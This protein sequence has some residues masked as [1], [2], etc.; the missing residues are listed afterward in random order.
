LRRRGDP[1]FNQRMRN[2]RPVIAFL[3]A[4]FL[5]R[6]SC[7][8]PE[9]PPLRGVDVGTI[10]GEAF[11]DIGNGRESVSGA[12]VRVA[13]LGVEEVTVAGAKFVLESIP[14]G[15]HDVI[16][17][18]REL[19]RAVRFKV[20]IKTA[21][22]TL[23]LDDA[24][25][26]LARAATVR[27]SVVVENPVDVD[28]FLVGGN[29]NDVTRPGDDGSYTLDSVPPGPAQIAFSKPGFDVAVV[30]INLA[31]GDNDLD[32][33]ALLRSTATNL[34]L[35]GSAQ[36]VGAFDHRGI[37][38]RLNDGEAVVTTEQTGAFTFEALPPGRY[39]LTASKPGFRTA[40]LPTVALNSS[41]AVFGLVPIFLQPGEDPPPPVAGEV[42]PPVVD[43]RAPVSGAV[44]LAGA[45]TAF[46]AAVQNADRATLA[47]TMS[48]D[49]GA[50]TAIGAG[51]PLVVTLPT[52]QARA[53]VDVFARLPDGTSDSATIF[54]DPIVPIVT[55]AAPR[56]GD[57]LVGGTAAVLDAD[58]R[59]G[60]AANLSWSLRIFGETTEVPLG[61]G[62]PVVVQLP[63][64]VTRESYE[65][66]ARLP[67]GTEDTVVVLVDPSVITGI[68]PFVPGAEALVAGVAAE[69]LFDQSGVLIGSRYTIQEG[70]PLTI[71]PAAGLT[72]TFSDGTQAFVGSL[73]LRNLSIGTHTFTATFTTDTGQQGTTIIEIVVLPLTFAIAITDPAIDDTSFDDTPIA[74]RA[75]IVHGFQ[76]GFLESAVSWRNQENVQIASGALTSVTL[77]A[78][79][80]ILTLEVRDVI[81]NVRTAVVPVDVVSL[82]FTAFFNAPTNGAR[83]LEGQQVRINVGFNHNRLTAEEAA[84]VVVHVVSDRVGRIA[85]DAGA[86]EFAPGTDIL[87]STLPA[88][89]HVLTA[90][91]FA[92]GRIATATTNITIE[93]PFVS[94]LLLSSSE[95]LAVPGEPLV[96][97][98]AASGGNTAVPLVHWFLDGRELD[99][100]WAG[101]GVDPADPA[102]QRMDFGVYNPNIFPFT[103]PRWFE[104]PHIVEAWVRTPDVDPS[105]GC[106]NDGVRAQC[107]AI[108]LELAKAPLV[109]TSN[110]NLTNPGTPEVWSGV[111]RLQAKVV[112]NGGRLLIQPGTQ[113]LIDMRS[114]ADPNVAVAAVDREIIL[115]AGRLEV[116]AE[117]GA[118][119]NFETIKSFANTPRWNGIHQGA[120]NNND[121]SL[122]AH[123]ATFRDAV[124]GITLDNVDLVSGTRQLILDGVTVENSTQGIRV[125]CATTIQNIRLRNIGSGGAAAFQLQHQPFCPSLERIDGLSI[126]GAQVGLQLFSATSPIIT[127]VTG[128]DIEGVVTRGIFAQNNVHVVLENSRLSGN[129]NASSTVGSLSVGIGA[130]A[131]V[132]DTVFDNNVNSVSLDDPGVLGFI[133]SNTRFQNTS[134]AIHVNGIGGGRP[135][136]VHASSFENANT[137]MEWQNTGTNFIEEA[138]FEGNF[139]GDAN[140]VGTV[141]R[142]LAQTPPGIIP[143]VPRVTDSRDSLGTQVLGITRIDNPL[144]TTTI[145]HAVIVEPQHM[146]AYN[147]ASQC[148][149]AIAHPRDRGFDAESNCTWRVGAAG[150][151]AAQATAITPDQDGCLA[152]LADGEHAVHLVCN[153]GAGQTVHSTRLLVDSTRYAGKIHPNG[154][155][156]SGTVLVDGDVIV[157]AGTTLTILPGTV[158]RFKDTDRMFRWRPFSVTNVLGN[159]RMRGFPTR[160]DIEVDG[161]LEV[162]GD[163]NNR[164][165]LEAESGIAPA[166]WGSITLADGNPAAL[167]HHVTVRGAD[168]VLASNSAFAPAN[169]P[170]YS[171]VEL[172]VEDS[173]FVYTGLC[174]NLTTNLDTLRNVAVAACGASAGVT[175]RGGNWLQTRGG[176]V[177]AWV[178]L[179]TQTGGSLIQPTLENI[180]ATGSATSREV[181]VQT[182]GN[183]VDLS[184]NGIDVSE[185]ASVVAQNGNQRTFIDGSI[186]RNYNLAVSANNGNSSLFIADS[187]FENGTR[188][189]QTN[190]N[191]FSMISSRVSNATSVVLL[192]P[193][194][195]QV[196]EARDSQFENVAVVFDLDNSSTGVSEAATFSFTGNNYIGPTT[197]V[198]RLRGAAATN[199]TTN[200]DM[201]GNHWGTADRNAILALIEDPRAD[202]DPLDDIVGRT[203]FSGFLASPLTQNTP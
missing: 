35:A 66:V 156:W 97:E 100:D 104:G 125:E 80:H 81:G 201:R 151:S 93:V 96:F 161:T 90:R 114:V 32:D 91:V 95:Q 170:S 58:V 41:G 89:R 147:G 85:D 166:R 146:H 99:P 130:S 13:G 82:I 1:A 180:I 150:S 17:E 67:D 176:N 20:S 39:T 23:I 22:Q 140:V 103:D 123:N 135:I 167:L 157:P 195:F 175:F 14:L 169:A 8:S 173:T 88:G 139:L 179:A 38:I 152:G 29:A 75:Q 124:N 158:V 21:F 42:A 46:D 57:I 27:G 154:E 74:L 101:Y 163:A 186:V 133:A 178:H 2:S 50:V 53:Q 19:G 44:F 83:I 112:I 34:P 144:P 198:M 196:M 160:I 68:D 148:I 3:G 153:N 63:E 59:D 142:T 94:S 115:Q 76:T 183:A 31:E 84:A 193:R 200:I 7:P 155:T 106:I 127:T 194:V 120:I 86:T 56:P 116:G 70:Q 12:V 37:T 52:V 40:T 203:D 62:A 79:P 71:E 191:V 69:E 117:N 131:E 174:P 92:A 202:A 98:I 136:E 11:V 25:T 181:F 47:W 60:V 122:I 108:N 45:Q 105:L 129:T 189:L 109:I 15:N 197:R 6:C 182:D 165:I 164:V 78:G 54:V 64:V 177:T 141:A 162:L 132:Y 72:A 192:L 172:D 9:P 145:P 24:I 137:V 188:I 184:L 36:L 126:E 18:H 118:E 4:I 190:I 102:R 43:I 51:A 187:A 185:V 138:R 26:T 121:R 87:V 110:L 55:I 16:I 113:V 149:P 119:V 65:V 30:D 28:V 199:L 171:I 143:N 107:H 48:I 49:G 134:K 159:I 128:A 61:A 73:P 168:S 33:I 77:P 5:A 111:V 10:I